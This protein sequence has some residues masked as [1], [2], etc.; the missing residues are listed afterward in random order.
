MSDDS[1]PVLER[2]NAALRARNA[3]LLSNLERDAWTAFAAARMAYVGDPTDVARVA[4]WMLD[5]W[6]KRWGQ[7]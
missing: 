4:D 5:E 2:S 7:P 3:D 1:N 6:R